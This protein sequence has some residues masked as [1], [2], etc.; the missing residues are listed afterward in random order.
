MSPPKI[1]ATHRKAISQ[2]GSAAVE[3]NPAL[4]YLR[5]LQTLSWERPPQAEISLLGASRE[6]QSAAG[7]CSLLASQAQL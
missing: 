1:L 5:W 7:A 4:N 6:Q 2:E 3:L